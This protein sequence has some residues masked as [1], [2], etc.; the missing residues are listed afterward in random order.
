MSADLPT[1]LL[2]S[3]NPSTRQQ[4]EAQLTQ[5][6]L[7]PGFV[8]ALLRLVLAG[9]EL[10]LDRPVRLAGCVYLKNLVKLRWEEV[11]PFR[12]L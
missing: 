1:L 8:L 5:L 3:L 6:S 11:R 10:G 9:A 12:F 7:Q 2:A 4:A